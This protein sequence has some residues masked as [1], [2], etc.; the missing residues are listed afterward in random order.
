MRKKSI[1]VWKDPSYKARKSRTPKKLTARRKNVLVKESNL[2]NLSQSLRRKIWRARKAAAGLCK[3]PL[4]AH[5][6]NYD[7]PKQVTCLTRS[8]HAKLHA[9]K[10]KK[11]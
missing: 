9:R 1:D 8:Q 11:K 7:K 10:G 5:H 3:Y 2:Y 6:P 4:E